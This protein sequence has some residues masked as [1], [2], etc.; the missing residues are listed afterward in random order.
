MRQIIDARVRK[1]YENKVFEQST[2]RELMST[3]PGE[4]VVSNDIK[5]IPYSKVP[6]AEM[7]EEIK[8]NVEGGSTI[9]S[10][11]LSYVPT[12]SPYQSIAAQYWIYR[13]CTDE[14]APRTLEEF[15][16]DYSNS[17]YTECFDIGILR[18]LVNLID[19]QCTQQP[20]KDKADDSEK[21][22]LLDIATSIQE[23]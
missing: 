7:F 17:E 8:Q 18:T 10:A 6:K 22:S 16:D 20:S 19:N 14:V 5:F 23:G 1:Y 13:N 21:S 11:V 12:T 2:Y 4:V 3:Y 9:N 15:L